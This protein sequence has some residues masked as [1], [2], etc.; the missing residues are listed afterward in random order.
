M[1]GSSHSLV[2]TLQTSVIWCNLDYDIIA[3]G[4]PWDPTAMSRDCIEYHLESS[5]IDYKLNPL[6]QFIG[7]VAIHLT[8]HVFIAGNTTQHWLTPSAQM[9]IWKSDGGAFPWRHGNLVVELRQWRRESVESSP[10]FI[11][12]SWTTSSM[13]TRMYG[14][15]QQH[16]YSE[17]LGHLN[18]LLVIAA[19]LIESCIF[20]SAIEDDL[21]ENIENLFFQPCDC[22]GK[23]YK[24]MKCAFCTQKVCDHQIH[25]AVM[26]CHHSPVTPS[27]PGPKVGVDGQVI[28]WDYVLRNSGMQ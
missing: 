13:W 9:L 11:T 7:V 23:F 6:H 8:K 18:L 24:E 5:F 20:S 22:K 14:Q 21:H 4:M 3:W 27:A 1:Y 2:Q 10:F 25:Q 16:R 15:Q 26:R 28:S 17:I 12:L 19:L